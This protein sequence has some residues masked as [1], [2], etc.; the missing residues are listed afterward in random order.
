[1]VKKSICSVTM[2]MMLLLL[3]VS[4]SPPALTPATTPEPQIPPHF[5]TY[6]S[7]GLFS[8]SYPPDW[9]PATSIMEE[10]FEEIKESMESTDPEIS[11]EGANMLF[12]G[13]KPI[14]EWYYPS[15]NIIVMPRSIGYWALDEIVEGEAQYSREN[16]QRY[17]EYSRIRTTVDGREAVI[18]DSE[19]YDPDFGMWRYLQ[20]YAV[21][22]K[23]VWCVTCGSELEDFKGYEDTFYSIVKSLRIL[24]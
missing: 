2:I 10:A 3:T 17:H 16:D 1:M 5:S 21:K 12:L 13:G 8:I 19:D 20:L 15:V 7:E 14:E 9:V 24:K 18:L 6:T 23:F 4:C 22:D 11:L